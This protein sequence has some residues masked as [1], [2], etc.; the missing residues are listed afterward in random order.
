MANSVRKIISCGLIIIMLVGMFVLSKRDPLLECEISPY[1]IQQDGVYKR[2]YVVAEYPIDV[3]MEC[4]KEDAFYMI[5]DYVVEKMDSEGNYRT[6]YDS[7]RNLCPVTE[8][9]L[10]KEN[11]YRNFR[12][13][14]MTL[15]PLVDIYG[16]GE[17][18]V[19]ELGI[20]TVDFSK[21]IVVDNNY[22][23]VSGE[24]L[25]NKDTFK[26]VFPI[27]RE[28]LQNLEIINGQANFVLTPEEKDEFIDIILNMNFASINK[29]YH[30][31]LI[32][33]LANGSISY[34]SN[35]RFQLNIPGEENCYIY[36]MTGKDLEGNAYQAVFISGDT[37]I[38]LDSEEIILYKLDAIKQ[39]GALK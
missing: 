7:S 31:Y 23:V 36:N 39:K 37:A 8:E 25:K 10:V 22:Y 30:N 34:G 3:R 26:E 4:W 35:Y 38:C 12:Y 32:M 28:D 1:D 9:E 11:P 13:L 17:Y 20:N 2:R 27:T 33:C 21:D 18:R 15:Q 16:D 29:S 14:E 6:I 19:L 5:T 24:H